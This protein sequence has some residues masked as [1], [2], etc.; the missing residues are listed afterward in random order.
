MGTGKVPLNALHTPNGEG[1]CCRGEEV[2]AKSAKL[3]MAN[4][5]EISSAPEASLPP[6]R[7]TDGLLGSVGLGVFL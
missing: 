7:N 6:S 5:G 2:M 3:V 4:G 1:K